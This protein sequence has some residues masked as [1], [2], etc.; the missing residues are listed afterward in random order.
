MTLTGILLQVTQVLQI[1]LNR[2]FD[3]GLDVDGIFGP[4]TKAA[5][6]NVRRGA[7]GNITQLIQ[8]MLIIQLLFFHTL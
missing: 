8:S 5:C 1:E 3:R 7:V 4:A 6:V 2:Q